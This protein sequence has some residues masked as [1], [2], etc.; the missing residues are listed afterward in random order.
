MARVRGVEHRR[1]GGGDLRRAMRKRRPAG[2]R[3]VAGPAPDHRRQR[4]ER[5]TRRRRCQSTTTG[6]QVDTP[7]PTTTYGLFE[8]ATSSFPVAG[9]STFT[10]ERMPENGACELMKT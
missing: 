7:A 6:A 5:A 4:Q 9:S 8:I 2:R 1:R 3:L 10:C